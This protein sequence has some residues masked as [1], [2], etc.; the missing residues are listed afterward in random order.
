[1]KEATSE[2]TRKV[3]ALDKAIKDAQK[4]VDDDRKAKDKAVS[5]KTKTDAKIA[6][7]QKKIGTDT[8]WFD[9][10]TAKKIPA[11]SFCFC[12]GGC[13]EET[14][15]FACGGSAVSGYR[16]EANGWLCTVRIKQEIDRE[17]KKRNKKNLTPL[18]M[19]TKS[20]TD[21]YIC[22]NCTMATRRA[23]TLK[24]TKKELE[25]KKKER[26]DSIQGW[27]DTIE[28]FKKKYP[29]SN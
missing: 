29:I 17:N 1:M 5:C 3:K 14:G 25:E 12:R 9:K 22:E 20:D 26:L 13:P 7:L 24:T 21:E 2:S 28:Q 19:P 6:S 27:E 23:A 16:C 18:R 8:A 10:N 4:V 11:K 15:M